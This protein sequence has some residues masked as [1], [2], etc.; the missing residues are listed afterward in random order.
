VPC[1]QRYD[2]GS[3]PASARASVIDRKHSDSPRFTEATK[4][5]DSSEPMSECNSKQR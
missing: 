3:P 5:P 4:T 2:V 1:K